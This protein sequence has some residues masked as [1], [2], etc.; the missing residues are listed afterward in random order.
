MHRIRVALLALAGLSLVW[1]CAAE[2]TEVGVEVSFAM[3]PL[4]E[5]AQVRWDLVISGYA[6]FTLAESWNLRTA[7]GINLGQMGLSGSVALLR[8]ISSDISWEGVLDVA[9]SLRELAASLRLGGEGF[10]GLSASGDLTLTTLPFQWLLADAYGLPGGA[11]VFAPDVFAEFIPYSGSGMLF[12][13]GL[14]VGLYPTPSSAGRA[15]IPVG[16][17]SGLG[18]RIATRV[19]FVP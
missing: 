14:G 8:P 2:V 9:W 15:A 17:H 13:Q 4:R 7:A 3:R 16:G 18:V 6:T 1:A 19:G 11:F 12:A 5:L 10:I